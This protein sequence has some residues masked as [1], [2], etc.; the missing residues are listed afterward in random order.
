MIIRSDI[1]EAAAK[2]LAIDLCCSPGDFFKNENTV[3]SPRI[4]DGRRVF[5]EEP[6]FFRAADMGMGAVICADKSVEPFARLLAEQKNGAEIFSAETVAV[7]NRELFSHGF[8]IGIMSQYFL[9]KTPY[10]PNVR[11]E[12]YTLTVFEGKDIEELYEYKGF[13]NALLYRTEG[14]RHDIIA[15]CAVNGRRI[16]GIA[17]ASCD[18]PSMAQVGI[19]VLPEFRGMGIGSALVSSC[20]AEVFRRGYVPY[21]GT[22]SGNI[23]SQRLAFHCGFY[24]A[25]CEMFSVKLEGMRRHNKQNN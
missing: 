5:T 13:N 21:Y 4:I 24:P 8:C 20:A 16:M 3:T 15:V 19:D 1:E 6:H 7:L 12:G 11:Y 14:A 10:R 9:P 22:W 25:W 2:Q 17:G 23:I 18:S